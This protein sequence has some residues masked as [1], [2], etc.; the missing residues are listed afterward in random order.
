MY[1]GIDLGTSNSSIA[2]NVGNYFR[3]FRTA[4]GSDILPS[5]LYVDKRGHKLFGKRAYDQTLL[6]PENVAAG[7]KRLMGTSTKIE[8]S[9]AGLSLLP[10]ECS[11]EILK[12][13]VGQ[14]FTE[15]GAD[16]IT[17][18]VITIPAAFNQMQ[19][20]AT[21]RAAKLAGLENVALLQEPIAAAMAAISQSKKK[22][23]QFLVY[24]LGGGTFDLA[25]VQ[26]LSGSV[27]IL[28]HEGINMLGG[29]DFDR[30]L[31]NSIIRP[32]LHNNFELPDDFQ[33]EEKYRRVVRIAQL[34]AERAKIEL[35]NK[36][37]ETIFASDEE[38]RVTDLNG[39]EIYLEVSLTR[40]ALENLIKEELEQTL[41]SSRKI[42]KDNGYSPSDI[43]RIV[44]VGGPTK[45]PIV[46]SMIPHELGI[47]SDVQIDPM[48]AVALGAAI[49]AESREWKSGKTTRKVARASFNGDGL[50]GLKFDYPSR[51]SDE[52]AKVRIKVDTSKLPIGYEFQID[53][54]T[55]W[56]SGRKAVLADLVVELP[57]PIFGENS[58]K[59]TIF[60]NQGKPFKEEGSQFKVIRTHAS[61]AGIPAT[62]TIAVR[63]R[64]SAESIRNILHPLIRKG[65]LLPAEGVQRFRAGKD[66]KGGEGDEHLE[67][68]LYQD[69]GS[70]EP[71][72]N[73]CIGVFKISGN[74][75]QD[76][77]RIREGDEIVFNWKMSDSGLLNAT[78]DLPTHSQT[79]DT[80]KFYVAQAGHESFDLESGSRLATTVLEKAKADLEEVKTALNGEVTSELE[81]AE[82][83]LEKQE[84]TLKNAQDPDTARAITEKTRHIRQAI[85]SVKHAPENRRMVLS[86]EIESKEEAFNSLCREKAEQKL[87][88][89][90]DSHIRSAKECLVRGDIKSLQEAERHLEEM[91]T[92]LT[93]QLW[94][95]PQYILEVFKRQVERSY[96]A[97]DKSQYDANVQNGIEAIKQNDVDEL[98]RI[99][100]KLTDLQITV[101]GADETIVKAA[102]IFRA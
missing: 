61:S 45:M 19:S 32:W 64:E 81:K 80:P 68:A 91:A 14:A 55:G 56:T 95:D 92:L 58:F 44:F 102:S 30:T 71:E 41:N 65:T 83:D 72:L 60:D 24:D 90:F 54:T 67:F 98:R 1:L 21:I 47:P 12:Q 50:I 73:L 35:S 29:R 69:E 100:F 26:S 53:S 2:G 97:T 84:E 18:T 76:G 27:S 101:G 49:Y 77:T 87:V 9:G 20:E 42:L 93:L 51:T 16:A 39:K 5:V 59:A 38:I 15:S 22:S 75:L 86:G 36:E 23:S 6:A 31:V 79:F 57:L 94:Q 13:L 63:V 78:L 66:L 43:D 25:L 70:I 52:N 37:Q 8:L 11:A 85:S 99:I 33:K 48:T 82:K 74:D 89:R 62:Q 7:F 34:A 3:V 40:D 88:E 10:E 46:R 4:E 17:G 96:L 28:A